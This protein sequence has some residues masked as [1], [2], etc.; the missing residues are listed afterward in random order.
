MTL[1]DGFAA[2][3]ILGTFLALALSILMEWAN[4]PAKPE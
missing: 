1:L 4:K 3:V 2:G